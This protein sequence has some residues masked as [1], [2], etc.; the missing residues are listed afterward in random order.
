MVSNLVNNSTSANSNLAGQV[1]AL[2]SAV[3]VK[4]FIHQ[5]DIG[6]IAV[7]LVRSQIGGEVHGEHVPTNVEQLASVVHQGS[8][9]IGISHNGALHAVHIDNHLIVI[10]IAHF[11]ANGLGCCE[12]VLT[13]SG[14]LHIALD[15]NVLS[16]TIIDGPEHLDGAVGKVSQGIGASV[17]GIGAVAVVHHD[18]GA[19]IHMSNNRC[20]GSRCR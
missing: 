15:V 1:V 5:I 6:D 7:G 8:H 4:G 17:G 16:E 10:G 9:H 14:L 13:E 12:Q 2:A 3:T 11:M 20:S 18:L 19:G